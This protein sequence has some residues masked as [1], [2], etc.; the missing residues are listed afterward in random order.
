MVGPSPSGNPRAEVRV[1][2]TLGTS[3]LVTAPTTSK[4]RGNQANLATG[5][6]DGGEVT[7]GMGKD[8]DGCRGTAG[9]RS[10]ARGRGSDRLAAC[11]LDQL[12]QAWIGRNEAGLRH[13]RQPVSQSLVAREDLV[14]FGSR[15]VAASLEV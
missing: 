6:L 4:R 2:T 1:I 14:E 3:S 9:Y 7:G 8:A 13:P 12:Q 11:L 10:T 15:V 5:G